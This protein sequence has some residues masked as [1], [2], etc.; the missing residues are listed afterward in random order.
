MMLRCVKEKAGREPGGSTGPQ[1]RRQHGEG[2]APQRVRA[3]DGGAETGG[4]VDTLPGYAVRRACERL[5]TARAGV[6]LRVDGH[7]ARSA[8]LAAAVPGLPSVV[9]HHEDCPPR[10][11][12][13]TV[14]GALPAWLKC[15][16]AQAEMNSGSQD[17]NADSDVPCSGKPSPLVSASLYV[18]PTVASGQDA[19]DSAKEEQVLIG[20]LSRLP[21]CDGLAEEVSRNR[22][23]SA[24]GEQRKRGAHPKRDA[25]LAPVVEGLPRQAKPGADRS[26][27]DRID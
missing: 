18:I 17:A 9:G 7:T 2:T 11:G 26:P 16:P 27:S 5:R 13:V 12:F 22:L 6:P 19:S 3:P 25:A 21:I 14:W 10:G 4:D 24:G 8:P 20:H 15:I 23:A 1:V